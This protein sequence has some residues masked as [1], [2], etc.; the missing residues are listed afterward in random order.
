M[1]EKSRGRAALLTIGLLGLLPLFYILNSPDSAPSPRVSAQSSF[2]IEEAEEILDNVFESPHFSLLS[3]YIEDTGFTIGDSVVEM[4]ANG[5]ESFGNLYQTIRRA[6]VDEFGRDL[7]VLQL[8][9][10]D[11]EEIGDSTHG[12]IVMGAV[13][14]STGD[15]VALVLFELLLNENGDGF[16]VL[17]DSLG[18]RS[19]YTT[20]DEGESIYVLNSDLGVTSQI[21]AACGI[22]GVVLW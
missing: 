8:A 15:I 7:V 18:Q 17:T 1:N 5:E 21:A 20:Y 11:P 16:I 4:Y 6:G 2:D 19:H 13:N 3:G 22:L 10:E 9:S 12:A 14:R